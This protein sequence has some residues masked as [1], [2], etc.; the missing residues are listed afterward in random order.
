MDEAAQ[1]GRRGSCYHWLAGDLDIAASDGRRAERKVRGG[2]ANRSWPL[3][4]RSLGA[5]QIQYGCGLGE[6]MLGE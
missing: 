3:Q 5:K 2:F 4:T 6:G 1:D